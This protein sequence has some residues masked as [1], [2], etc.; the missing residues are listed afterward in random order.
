MN[1]K[2]KLLLNK[3]YIKTCVKCKAPTITIL[4]PGE[5][6]VPCLVKDNAV[7]IAEL[8]EQ[9]KDFESRLQALE[10]KKKH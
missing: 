4:C 1:F 9:F 2:E 10:S 6:C 5:I 3:N 7:E 8:K